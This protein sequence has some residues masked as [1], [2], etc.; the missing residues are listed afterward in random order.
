MSQQ[1]LYWLSVPQPELQVSFSPGLFSDVFRFHASMAPWLDFG[2]TSVPSSVPF[3]VSSSL[4]AHVYPTMLMLR[5]FP[6]VPR[7]KDSVCAPHLGVDVGRV[8][9]TVHL[10]H[11][12]APLIDCFLAPECVGCRVAATGQNPRFVNMPRAAAESL[13]TRNGSRHPISV[14][15]CFNWM[16]HAAA[17]VA[18]YNSVSALE[19][20]PRVIEHDSATDCEQFDHDTTATFLR[21]VTIAASSLSS[22]SSRYSSCVPTSER[23]CKISICSRGTA[24]HGLLEPVFHM[25]H[26]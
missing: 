2:V 20:T 18:A 23:P 13:S 10:H 24:H 16:P 19:M 5:R 21:S 6:A 12:E 17:R 1:P 26:A 9:L 7:G 4:D 11:S 3:I 15:N 22:K 14:R 25:L 8:A